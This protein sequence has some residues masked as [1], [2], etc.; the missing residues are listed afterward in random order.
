M[1]VALLGLGLI[2]GSIA[3]ALDRLDDGD[4]PTLVAWTPSGSGSRAALEAGVVDATATGAGEAIDGSSLVVLAGPPT[5]C[6]TMIGSLGG[7]LR[8]A[9]AADATVTDVAST[10]AAIVAAANDAG[11]PFVGGHPMA[12]RETSG[13]EAATA[14]L[15]VDRPW[16]LVPGA[17]SRAVDVERVEWLARAC[18]ARPVN[19]TARQHDAAVGAVSHLPLVVSA[20]IVESVVGVGE[21]PD[22]PDW[23]LAESLAATGWE[24][25]TRLAR[26]DPEMGAGI[27]V[28]NATEV[29]MRL[30]RLQDAIDGWIVALELEGGPDEAGLARRLT[31]TRR[32]LDREPS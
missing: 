2:G 11:L 19:M 23:A 29:A 17:A 27:L 24:S 14:D 25:M 13:F 10:K 6:L 8:D 7:E 15:F 30:H 18:G 26:G 16:V 20:A 9:L 32:R 3:R 21:Q 12:G 4:R 31:T 5:A 28:T 1:R 22:S